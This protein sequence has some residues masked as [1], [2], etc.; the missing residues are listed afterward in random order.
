M[1]DP[2]PTSR[3]APFS[4]YAWISVGEFVGPVY[5]GRLMD[6][7]GDWQTAGL[8]MVPVCLIGATTGMLMR[9]K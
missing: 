6:L 4:Q 5:F 9:I 1:R 8:F 2:G 7:T 3:Q